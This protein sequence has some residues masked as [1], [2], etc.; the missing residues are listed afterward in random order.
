M[1]WLEI[2]VTTDGEAAEAISELLRPYAYGDGVVLE[3]LGDPQNPDPAA[4]EPEVSVKIYLPGDED[5][6][7]LRRKIEEAIYHMGRLYPISPPNFKKLKDED[8][9]TAWKKNYK[10]FRVGKRILIQPS[11][12]EPL[13]RM[14]NEIVI[15]MD[16]G[17]AFGTGLHPS[18]QMCL[19][20][21][22][23]L[24]H[25]DTRMLDVGTG[26]GILSI[27]AAKLGA[28]T[29]VAFDVDRMAIQ[30]T[31]TNAVQNDVLNSIAIFQGYLSGIYPS[32][33][34][35]VVVNILAPI[36]MSMIKEDNLLAYLSDGG[37]LVLS[38]IIKDQ[39]DEINETVENAGGRVERT[40]S[41][42]DWIT[43]VVAPY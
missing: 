14:G 34:D 25:K 22:E 37:R 32:E 23:E 9:A 27:A 20:I 1:H 40:L 41:V 29:T 6:P 8:W 31:Y 43:W 16:P 39:E 38:G 15:F 30:A 11:W 18:T 2:N 35:L 4:L 5:T 17:M 10:P 12:L 21:I 3:Q 33:W 36:I 7:K 28:K 24:V 26:S 19:R 42:R 13:E